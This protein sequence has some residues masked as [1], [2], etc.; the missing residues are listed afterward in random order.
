MAS[1]DVKEGEHEDG[2][3]HTP[4]H[5]A[6]EWASTILQQVLLSP[7][8]SDELEELRV[9]ALAYALTDAQGALKDSLPEHFQTHAASLAM[10]LSK[11]EPLH[12]TIPLAV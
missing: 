7:L 9:D 3:T 1:Q 12:L 6:A 5:L 2:C 11:V 8:E 10:A 4:E